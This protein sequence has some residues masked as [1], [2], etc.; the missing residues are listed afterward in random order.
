MDAIMKTIESEEEVP[1]PVYELLD[2][3]KHLSTRN[4]AEV[5]HDATQARDE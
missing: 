3:Y 4:I 1:R 2:A 5:L